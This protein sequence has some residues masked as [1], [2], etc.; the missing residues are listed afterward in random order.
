MLT[1]QELEAVIM[2]HIEK[3]RKLVEERGSGAFPSL[4]GSIMSEVRGS[5]DP[6]MVT[7]KLKDKL[8]QF[9]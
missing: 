2:R 9:R 3:N 1:E 8:G 5:T 4:M 7:E 6:K